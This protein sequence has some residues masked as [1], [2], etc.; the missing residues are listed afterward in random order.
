MNRNAVA[1]YRVSTFSQGRSGLGLDGQRASVEAYC[2]Q[3]GYE[4]VRDFQEVESGKND[5]RPKLAE[6]LAFAKRCK[7]VLIVARLDRLARSVAFVDGVMRSGV[8]FVAVDVP[9]ANSLVLHI[10]AAVAQQEALSISQ[11]TKAALQAARA[12]G[13]A[14]GSHNPSV[15][16]LT[17]EA[18]RMGAALGA[19]AG[20][21]KAVAEYAD[22][23]PLILSLH[24]QGTSLRAIA[25]RLNMDGHKTR[26]GSAWSAVQVLRVLR[27]SSAA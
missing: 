10:L 22:L 15:P 11:R 23:L 24:R 19:Q 26:R 3:N 21:R 17:L 4:L 27:R 7:A 1:Y 6:A 8:E 18:S 25:E 20:H 9:S 14:L 13:T 2:S 16:K 5:A 12:R